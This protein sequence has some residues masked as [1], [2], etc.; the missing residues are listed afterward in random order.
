MERIQRNASLATSS[1]SPAL[2]KA[3]MAA[4]YFS[5]RVR[6]MPKSSQLS[7]SSSRPPLFKALTARFQPSPIFHLAHRTAPIAH[8]TCLHQTFPQRGSRAQWLYPIRA[9]AYRHGPA[10]HSFFRFLNTVAIHAALQYLRRLNRHIV[11]KIKLCH[12]G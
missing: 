2:R 12:R 3:L 6:A 5:S 11:I 8:K 9:P 10:I 4:S 1:S 7:A